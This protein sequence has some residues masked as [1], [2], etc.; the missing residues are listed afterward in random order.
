MSL[1]GALDKTKHFE[2]FSS[3]LSTAQG[4]LSPGTRLQRA[5]ANLG[6]AGVAGV[7][8]GVGSE[9]FVDGNQGTA[10]ATGASWDEALLTVTSVFTNA[11]F[12][13]GDVIYVKGNIREELTTPAGIFDVAIIGAGYKPR[14]ADTH[15]TLGGF[16]AMATWRDPASGATAIP[17]LK[18]QQQGWLI[19][20]IMFAM[21]GTNTAGIQV[22]ADTGSG[23]DERDASHTI[24]TGCHFRGSGI[25]VQTHGLPNDVHIV[26]NIF[27]NL[28]S[29]IVGTVGA[30][31]KTHQYT[32]ITGNQFAD[33]TNGIVAP[34]ARSTIMGNVFHTTMTKEIDLVNGAANIVTDNILMN[35]YDANVAATGDLWYGNLSKDTTSAEVSDE[36]AASPS[37]YTYTVPVA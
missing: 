29:C 31:A 37:G 2:E 6:L 23:N 7:G 34:L 21:G 32:R 5:R 30:G 33:S 11:A 14:H 26:G 27:D 13:S 19:A 9:W 4:M 8:L 1:I 3:P 28:T 18:V 12:A 16:N 10:G 17:H 35:N 20:N 24:I 25:G 15:T 36:L 22:F